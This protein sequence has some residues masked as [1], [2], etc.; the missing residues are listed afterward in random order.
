MCNYWDY[1]VGAEMLFHW[2]WASRLGIRSPV[3]VRGRQALLGGPP[4]SGTLVEKRANATEHL[5]CTMSDRQVTADALP[6]NRSPFMGEQPVHKD[7]D[8][9]PGL[10]SSTI[11]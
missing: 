9:F 1:Q 3:T 7:A 4:A 10:Y 5:P 8:A 11:Q 2:V 6:G